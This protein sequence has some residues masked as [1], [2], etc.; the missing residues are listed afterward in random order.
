ME[1]PLEAGSPHP[2]SVRFFTVG[3]GRSIPHPLTVTH[4]FQGSR[5]DGTRERTELRNDDVIQVLSI[6]GNTTERLEMRRG[7]EIKT[8]VLMSCFAGLTNEGSFDE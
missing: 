7:G 3:T 8:A 6:A 2:Q 4:S 5:I 1:Q